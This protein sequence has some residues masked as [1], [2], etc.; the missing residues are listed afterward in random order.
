MTFNLSD[1]YKRPGNKLQGLRAEIRFGNRSL[2]CV[3]FISNYTEITS[4]RDSVKVKGGTAVC[5][6]VC[7]SSGLKRRRTCSVIV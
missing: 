3:R 1:C 5:V 7:G 4:N 2:S 6:G